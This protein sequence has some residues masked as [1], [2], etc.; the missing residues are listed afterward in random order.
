MTL[1]VRDEA[2][3]ET[4]HVHKIISTFLLLSVG[5]LIVPEGI[6]HPAVSVSTL[7]Y[8][9]RYICYCNK[10]FLYNIIIIKLKPNN[11]I[12]R[13]WL[14]CLGSMKRVVRTGAQN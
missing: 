3:P 7:T 11:N 8:I 13:F 6:L 10:Q 1:S 9:I 12:R 5:W 2:I 14:S 4:C